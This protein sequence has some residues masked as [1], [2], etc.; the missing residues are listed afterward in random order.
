V[1]N[2]FGGTSH[3]LT[4]DKSILQQ[5]QKALQAAHRDSVYARVDGVVRQGTFLLMELE[6][7]EPALFLESDPSAA[8][9]FAQGIKH[10][11]DE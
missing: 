3:P 2:E 7:I 10:R 8:R 6:L 4:P 5:A 9:R 1:Q 11:L